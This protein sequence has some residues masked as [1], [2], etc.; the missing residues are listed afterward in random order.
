MSELHGGLVLCSEDANCIWCINDNYCFLCRLAVVKMFGKMLLMCNVSLC[1]VLFRKCVAAVIA[2]SKFE[3]TFTANEVTKYYRAGGLRMTVT[4]MWQLFIGVTL[5]FCI[6][7]Q[8]IITQ[9]QLSLTQHS[10]YN[11]TLCFDYT[12]DKRHALHVIKNQCGVW[13]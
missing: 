4:M 6:E 10:L 7:D 5:K 1:R 3:M 2:T 11:I 8:E 12:Q 9:F 13:L